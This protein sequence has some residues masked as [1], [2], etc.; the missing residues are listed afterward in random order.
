MSIQLEKI[1]I[2]SVFDWGDREYYAS[3]LF[4]SVL[5]TGYAPDKRRQGMRRRS[6]HR[7]NRRSEGNSHHSG[8]ESPYRD[9]TVE[10]NLDLFMRM[11][12]GNLKKAAMCCAPKS[13]W[14]R[15]NMHFRDP[16]MYRIIKHPSSSYGND[17]ESLSHV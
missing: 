1:Y 14:R 12:A 4:P 2:G 11:N 16:I 7:G 17:M 13:I 9:R 15:S 10:E 6:D 8:I 3:G 5:R